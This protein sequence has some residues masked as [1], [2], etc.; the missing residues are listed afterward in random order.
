M[1][2]NPLPPLPRLGISGRLPSHGC[3]VGYR[4]PPLR[5]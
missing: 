4:L 5:G 1:P 2:S 3:A